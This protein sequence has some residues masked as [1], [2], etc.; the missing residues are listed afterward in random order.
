MRADL[1]AMHADM[2]RVGNAKRAWVAR[3]S[4]RL[5]LEADEGLIGLGEAAPLPGRSPETLPE[6]HRA[7][8]DIRWPEA[9]LT[10]VA[11]IRDFVEGAIEASLPSA[12]FAAEAALLGL[13]GA[14]R[15]VPIH[16]LLGA[17]EPSAVPIAHALFAEDDE[18][19]FAGLREA[20][21]FGS[22]AIKLKVGRASRED[23]ERRWLRAVR[24][25]LGDV[26]LRLDAN[27]SIA[28][29]ALP[30]FLARLASFEPAFIEEPAPFEALLEVESPFPYALDE[31]LAGP[32]AA[33]RLERAIDSGRFGAIVLKP[34][35]I[36]GLLPSLALAERGRAAGL[37]VVISHLLEG[38]IARAAAAHLA[39][40]FGPTAAGLGDHPALDL[41]SDGLMTS[42]IDLAWIEPPMAPGLAL[43]VVW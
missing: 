9:P 43:E 22:R 13:L 36:G 18:A 23:D 6:A 17:G 5:I 37:E 11:E 32:G 8:A 15:G 14:S 35:L 7:L 26:E 21:A 2:P 34:S 31:S 16:A 19:V 12:R 42:W 25:E 30:R 39:V 33:E 40:S 3:S 41:L 24:A 38:P 27:Q 10:E 20:D 29:D 28:V 1:Q 4:L